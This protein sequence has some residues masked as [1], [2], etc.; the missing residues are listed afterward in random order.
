MIDEEPLE[1]ACHV[2]SRTILLKYGCGQALKV[3]KDNRL[4]HLGDVAL[5][6]VHMRELD[7]PR[8]SCKPSVPSSKARFDTY[9]P[10][11]SFLYYA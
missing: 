9:R 5:S 10:D 4:K 7:R 1:Y 3:R 2:W 8:N 11:L 6:S